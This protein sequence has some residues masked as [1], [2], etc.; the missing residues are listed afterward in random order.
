MY[1][2]TYWSTFSPAVS[3]TTVQCIFILALLLGCLMRSIDF[4][5]P[6]TQAKVKTDIFMK[7]LADNTIPN[8]NP[9]KH[10]LKLQQ[11]FYGLKDGQV[12]WHEHIKA[13]L[14]AWHFKQSQVDPC[15]FIKGQVLL[16]LYVDNAALFSPSA[17]A[18]NT[19]IQSLQTAFDH[20]DEGELQDYLG[21]HF[22]RHPDGMV[23]SQQ[24]KM[25]NNC[26]KIIGMG[27]DNNHIKT[28]D[29]PAEAIKILHADQDGE[30][31]KATWNFCAVIGGLNYLQ[32]MT[33]PDLAYAVHQCARFCNA[34]KP[35]SQ[36]S[37]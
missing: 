13:G 9:L 10:L 22:T 15:L 37:L 6:Y 1:G 33:W 19:E 8:V 3:W 14:K 23:E 27:Y 31:R 12:T 16:V 35:Q 17:K 25:I 30:V 29:T 26:L 28:H 34:P 24:Y 7:L 2:D 20:T 18:L 11:Y 5:M 21:T 4:V 32:A 36:M